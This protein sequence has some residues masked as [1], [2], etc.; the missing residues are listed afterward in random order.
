MKTKF[1][2]QL[3]ICLI[4][5]IIALVSCGNTASDHYKDGYIQYDAVKLTPEEKQIVNESLTSLHKQYDLEKKMITS[6][7]NGYNYHTDAQI[8]VFHQVRASFAYAVLLLDLGDE[9]YTQR[10]FNVIEKTIMLQDQDSTSKSCGVWPYYME[11]PLATKKSPID[12]NWADFNAVSLLEVWMGH[13]DRIPEALKAKIKHALILAANS[14]QKRNVGPDYTNIAIMGTYVTYMVSHLFD[15]PEMK[16]YAPKRLKNF[17]H[18]TLDKDGFSEYNS[19]NYTI[20]A[21]NEL[22]RMKRHIVEPSDK[23][24]VDSLYSIGWEIIARHYHQPSGQ[25]AGPHSRSYSTLVRPSFYT[26]LKEGSNG[27]IDIGIEEK[28][29]DVKIKHQIPEYLLHY[30]LTPEYPRTET[31]VFEK[32]EPK[33]I[34]TTYLTTTYALSTANRSSLWNQRRPFLVYWGNVQTPKYLQVR[35]LHDNYDFSSACFFSSQKENKVLAAINFISNGGDKHISIDRLKDGKFKAKDFRLRFE[36]GN[37]KSPEEL[38]FPASANEPFSF[39]LN[40]LKFNLQLSYAVFENMKGHWEKG[41]DGKISWIDFVF[42]SGSETE[43]DLTKIN[44][45][46]MSFSFSLETSGDAT[47]IKKSK[48]S[49]K[50]GLMKVQWNGLE[51]EIP[52]KPQTPRK[53]SL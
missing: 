15:L 14:I 52:V 39:T 30:F 45:A 12:F 16:E 46:A 24:I 5:S 28:R 41:G 1:I 4:L 40:N 43:F 35:F 37:V 36:F 33:T 3:T 32:V 20:V 11:E 19:P 50:K 31:D 22:Y 17:Y 25:W 38:S 51:L 13:Q 8:G 26:I 42:Y 6:T 10:A 47:A 48:V 44:M 2:L 29:S 7:L 49:E 21:L 53:T 27:K 23:K 34:G 9:Q 18:Y